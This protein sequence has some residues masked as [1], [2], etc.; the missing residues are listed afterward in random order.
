LKAN[1]AGAKALAT[2]SLLLTGSV[3]TAGAGLGLIGASG[4]SYTLGATGTAI[5]EGLSGGLMLSGG[6][7][8]S[9]TT[10]AG[11]FEG[12]SSVLSLSCP[13]CLVGGAIGVAAV[14]DESGLQLGGMVGGLAEGGLELALAANRLRRS[15]PSLQLEEQTLELSA[16]GSK[17]ASTSQDAVADIVGRTVDPQRQLKHLEGSAPSGKSYV[18]SVEDAQAVVDAYHNGAARIIRTNSEQNTVTVEVSSVTGRYLS[19][20]DPYGR[21]DLDIPT[22]VFDIRGLSP[23]VVPVNPAKATQ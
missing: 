12:A 20:N 18:A 13:T 11:Q 15:C 6:V 9:A 17:A 8:A 22:N 2:G 7:V 4:T 19:T 10:L 21:P 3:L 23:K 16:A 14:G 5:W 1:A